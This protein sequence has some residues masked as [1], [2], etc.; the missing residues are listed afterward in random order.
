MKKKKKTG[1]AVFYPLQVGS[2]R[3]VVVA[4]LLWAHEKMATVIWP[5]VWGPLGPPTNFPLCSVLALGTFD[6]FSE[7]RKRKKK[8]ERNHIIYV[9]ICV[10]FFT[11]EVDCYSILINR[12]IDG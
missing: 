9:W 4:R 6:A 1:I 8:E 2:Q 3:L 10:S 5:S 12:P 7:K 11:K